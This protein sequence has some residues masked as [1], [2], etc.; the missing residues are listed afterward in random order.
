M[1]NSD[2][3]KKIKG[4]YAI[5]SSRKKEEFLRSYRRRELDYRKMLGMQFRYMGP[6]LTAVCCYVLILL[7][8]AAWHVDEALAKMLAALMPA[9][10][11]VVLTGLGKSEKYKMA[12]IESASRFSLRMIRILRLAVTGGA[13]FVVMLTLSVILKIAVGTDLLISFAMAGI[14]YLLTTF[15]CMMLIR[16][17]HSGKN[18]YGCIGIAFGVCVSVWQGMRIALIFPAEL[19]RKILLPVL[20]ASILMT[21]CETMKY[22]NEREVL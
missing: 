20:L 5:G 7:L 16:K 13:A 11:L 9:A 18:I 10:A 2:L 3:K 4:A 12:E 15:L 6:Q 17:W 19:C 21:V 1:T 22:I 8:A 14:P